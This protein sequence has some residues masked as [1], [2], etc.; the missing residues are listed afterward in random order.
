MSDLSPSSSLAPSSSSL[1]P[2]RFNALTQ[3]QLAAAIA[4]PIAVVCFLILAIVLYCCCS[5]RRRRN[6]KRDGREKSFTGI[7]GGLFGTHD[8]DGDEPSVDEDDQ[9]DVDEYEWDWIEPRVATPGSNSPRFG[10]FFHRT[11]SGGSSPRGRASE[12][13]AAPLAMSEAQTTKDEASPM[14]SMGHQRRPPPASLMAGGGRREHEFSTRT[15][16]YDDEEDNENT[17][18]QHKRD[19]T[20]VPGAA[21]AITGHFRDTPLVSKHRAAS[22]LGVGNTGPSLPE[23]AAAS[24]NAGLRRISGG[25]YGNSPESNEYAYEPVRAHQDRDDQDLPVQESYEPY[26][27]PY[28]PSPTTPQF[29]TLAPTISTVSSIDPRIEQ[30][31][32]VQGNTSSPDHEDIRRAN[33]GLADL[34]NRSGWSVEGSPRTDATGH[35]YE[36]DNSDNVTSGED[37]SIASSEDG[38]SFSRSRAPVMEEREWMSGGRSLQLPRPPILRVPSEVSVSQYS[39]SDVDPARRISDQ[40]KWLST[41]RLEGRSRSRETSGGSVRSDLSMGNDKYS[42]SDLFFNTP[43]WNGARN[44]INFQTSTISPIATVSAKAP[45]GNLT[46][47]SSLAPSSPSSSPSTDSSRF[48]DASIDSAASS[49]DNNVDAAN[50]AAYRTPPKSNSRSSLANRRGLDDSLEDSPIVYSVVPTP[51]ARE[52]NRSRDDGDPTRADRDRDHNLEQRVQS[53]RPRPDSVEVLD[54]IAASFEAK[55]IEQRRFQSEQ[56]SQSRPNEE[57]WRPVELP[58]AVTPPSSR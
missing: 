17:A 16:Q 53:R 21:M 22:G 55:Q 44:P 3:S 28:K 14:M 38:R 40:R 51:T 12:R 32:A 13:L 45:A 30:G 11:I 56:R 43:R 52:R 18:L 5:R 50:Q 47:P 26:W 41:P 34:T 48:A 20:G 9:G 36:E 57:L 49:K 37:E 39:Q 8:R 54:R 42:V 19:M 25:R 6:R 23:R 4:T 1:S 7:A 27:D 24:L 15:G 33:L 2:K 46:P 58:V 10:G 29:P 35:D 31:D